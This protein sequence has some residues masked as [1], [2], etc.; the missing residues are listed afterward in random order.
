[1]YQTI[2]TT[3]E[4]NRKQLPVAVERKKNRKQLPV[5]VE[6]EKCGWI[7]NGPMC[8]SIDCDS[9]LCRPFML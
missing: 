3:Y 1:M 6:C 9:E 7:A 4:K 5:V 2:K 8:P